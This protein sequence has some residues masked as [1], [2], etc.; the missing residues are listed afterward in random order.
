M[1]V[2]DT[3]VLAPPGAFNALPVLVDSDALLHHLEQFLLWRG[4]AA[5]QDVLDARPVPGQF[6]FGDGLDN[7]LAAEAVDVVQ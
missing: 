2:P 6:A 7:D 5:P 4:I 1:T 3:A